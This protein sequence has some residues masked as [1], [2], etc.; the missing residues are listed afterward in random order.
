MKKKNT[1]K[2]IPD[3]LGRFADSRLGN[4]LKENYTI[5]EI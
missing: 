1:A 2:K 5:D 4:M 3:G